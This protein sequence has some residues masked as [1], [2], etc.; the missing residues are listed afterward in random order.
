MKKNVC[1]ICNQR[2]IGRFCLTVG[3]LGS[4]ATVNDLV[5]IAELSPSLQGPP[6]LERFR[7]PSE[8]K[9]VVRKF[10]L[11]SHVE[12]HACPKC[13]HTYSEEGSTSKIYVTVGLFPD[14]RPGEIF[15]RADKAG[16]L[17]AG[18]LDGFA[19]VTSLALQYGVPMG[20]IAGKLAGQA[21]PPQ[22]FTGDAEYPRALSVLDL[23]GRWLRDKFVPKA[24]VVPADPEV[25]LE[26]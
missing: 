26:G 6:K 19:I 22:G 20:Q 8:R 15:V 9:S 12:Q 16:S 10:K 14:G 18:L 4:A 21:F 2:K 23:L 11:P 5:T 24:E 17:L 3:C 1:N 25:K 13:K 7:L